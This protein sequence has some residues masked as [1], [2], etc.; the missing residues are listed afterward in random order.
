MH[1]QLLL[2]PLNDIR[3]FK[4]FSNLLTMIT[5]ND[6]TLCTKLFSLTPVLVYVCFFLTVYVYVFVS[7]FIT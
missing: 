5:K 6:I 1:V 2:F 4:V 3:L 7:D